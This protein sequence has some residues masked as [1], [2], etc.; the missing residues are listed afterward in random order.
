MGLLDV[1][2]VAESAERQSASAVRVSVHSNPYGAIEFTHDAPTSHGEQSI[3][4]VVNPAADWEHHPVGTSPRAG[5]R[6]VRGVRECVSVF[7]FCVS[8]KD[9]SIR[10]QAC[11]CTSFAGTERR[12]GQEFR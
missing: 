7:Q 9:N 12:V 2:S 10:L 6:S 4:K 5:K 3:G 8:L 1:P 11:R